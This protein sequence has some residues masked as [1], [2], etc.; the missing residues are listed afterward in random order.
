MFWNG[1]TAM[2]GLS[3]S[4][5]AGAWPAGEPGCACAALW[6]VKLNP[7]R[8]HW[9]GNVLEGLR[10]KVVAGNLDLA[11]DLPI[12]VIRNADAARLCNAFKPCGDVDAVTENV[13]VI[14]NDVTDMD[15]DAEFDPLILRYGGVLLGNAA[16]HFNRTSN[17]IDCAGKFNQHAVAGCLDDAASMGSYCGVNKGLSDRLEPGQRAFLVGTHQAAVTGDIRRQNC[18]Q[19]SINAFAAHQTPRNRILGCIRAYALGLEAQWPR[20]AKREIRAEW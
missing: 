4:G 17:R 14:K 1:S 8:P 7:P 2:E 19:P 16:L 10:P 9:L 6:P 12:G 5:S 15:T 13:V 18:R 20:R 11:P 3:G